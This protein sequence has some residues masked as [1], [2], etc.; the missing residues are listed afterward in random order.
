MGQWCAQ[1]P[2]LCGCWVREQPWGF[3]SSGKLGLV[4]MTKPPWRSWHF[5]GSFHIPRCL[6]IQP[7][8][9]MPI[10]PPPGW[11]QGLQLL[12]CEQEDTW[13]QKS[14]QNWGVK[15]AIKCHWIY[16]I[17][18][19]KAAWTDAIKRSKC[20]KGEGVLGVLYL[21][22]FFSHGMPYG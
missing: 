16:C 1:C 7:Q 20:K 21:A 13:G 12:F 6:I 22:F 14:V 5:P 10:F 9:R 4:S 11:S 18:E 19:L 3:A 8:K 17:R 15:K 2:A